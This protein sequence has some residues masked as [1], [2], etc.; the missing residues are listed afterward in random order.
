MAGGV[1]KSNIPKTLTCV[2]LLKFLVRQP[3]RVSL[4]TVFQPIVK[5]NVYTKNH[6]YP[7]TP[8]N[9]KQKPATLPPKPQFRKVLL[10][11][12][13]VKVKKKNNRQAN[14]IGN[15]VIIIN[16]IIFL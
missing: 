7:T 15:I 2:E 8:L 14:K 9:Y 6:Y 10:E 12:E 11:R 16:T 5:Q 1:T 13:S 4:S 3:F